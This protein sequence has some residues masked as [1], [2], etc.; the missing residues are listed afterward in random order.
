MAG[1][2]S[3]GWSKFTTNYNSGSTSDPNGR[4]WTMPADK[5][6]KLIEEQNLIDKETARIQKETEMLWELE[7]EIVSKEN[8]I[9]MVEREMKSDVAVV[10][11][12][13][14]RLDVE[15]DITKEMEEEYRKRNAW[16]IDEKKKFP[17][18]FPE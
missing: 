12:L 9:K 6:A 18:E 11:K 7:E 3:Q 13:C 8:W 10:N 15:Q 2:P 1:P 5:K 4:P 17:L 14:F 16:V